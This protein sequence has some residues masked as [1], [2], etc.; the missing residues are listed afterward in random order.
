MS[1]R[2]ALVLLLLLAALIQLGPEGGAE[3]QD[4]QAGSLDV[5]LLIDQSVSMWTPSGQY[6]DGL[7]NDPGHVRVSAAKLFLD[8]LRPAVQKQPCSIAIPR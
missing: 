4:G 7:V 3:A 2:V 6:E 1:R 8:L 5:A